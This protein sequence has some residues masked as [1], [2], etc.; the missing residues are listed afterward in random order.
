MG[1][2]PT[3][4]SQGH[5]AKFSL[6][7]LSQLVPLIFINIYRRPGGCHSSSGV[8]TMY[9]DTQC[10]CVAWSNLRGKGLLSTVFMESWSVPRKVS[11]LRVASSLCSRV[12]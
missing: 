11:A 2:C 7:H 1:V 6:P 10:D 5:A 9:P 8:E 3:Q 4:P 12:E